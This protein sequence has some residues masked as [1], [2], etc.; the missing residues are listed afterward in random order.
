MAGAAHD[1]KVAVVTGGAGGIGAAIA[2]RLASDGAQVVVA[3]VKSPVAEQSGAGLRRPEYIECDVSSER[4][5]AA[6]CDGFL[7]KYKR[8]DILVN[9]AGVFASRGFAETTFAEWRRTFAI[10]LDVMFLM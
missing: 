5:V 8:C 2:A 6:F 7:A 4:S 1:G 3:D 9:N 10:N